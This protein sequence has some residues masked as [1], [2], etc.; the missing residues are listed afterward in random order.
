MCPHLH[1]GIPEG[2]VHA[3]LEHIVDQ[4]KLA[5]CGK[6]LLGA[7]GRLSTL[8]ARIGQSRRRMIGVQDPAQVVTKALKA[9]AVTQ[10]QH[11]WVVA[12]VAVQPGGLHW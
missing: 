9:S 7:E 3:V 11:S 8:T 5:S 1:N 2:A 6:H 10:A 12:Q 4:V